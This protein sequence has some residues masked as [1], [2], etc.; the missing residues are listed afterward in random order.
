MFLEESGILRNPNWPRPDA[1][2]I[3]DHVERY[4][5]RARLR[6]RVRCRK[7]QEAGET[8]CAKFARYNLGGFHIPGLAC[9]R[10]DFPRISIWI[11][12]EKGEFS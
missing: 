6:R 8:Q 10:G 7:N 3:V 11:A 9:G 5:L 12:Q 1:Q 2:I 4:T